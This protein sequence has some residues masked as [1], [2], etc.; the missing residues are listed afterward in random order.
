MTGLGNYRGR[1]Q[2]QRQTES[3]RK[4]RSFLTTG[5][6]DD[7]IVK[8][9]DN[10]QLAR[11]LARILFKRRMAE[12]SLDFDLPEAIIVLN[13]KG[14]IID[15]G[16]RVRLES[17]RLIEEFMLAA[18]KASRLHVFRMGQKFLYRVHDKPDIEK[19]EALFISGLERSVIVSR[20]PTI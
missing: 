11:N 19:L 4:C 8:V 5:K 7:A 3:T 20:C 12:G 9:A 13:N 16:N 6:A 17:H 14:E 18:N 10:L 15:I 2:L 1:H